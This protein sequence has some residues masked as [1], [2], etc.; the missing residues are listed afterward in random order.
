MSLFVR[1]KVFFNNKSFLE[2]V[3]L[4][5]FP[6]T[7]C[8]KSSNE[9][10]PNPADVKHDVIG[11]PN[12][13]SN[14]RPVLFYIPPNET[15]LEQDF[16]IEREKVQKWNED[17]WIKHNSAFLKE[18]NDF[19]QKKLETLPRDEK[20]GLSAEEMSE[21][22]KAFLDKNWKTHFSYNFQW[23]G[24]NFNLLYLA[25]KVQISKLRGSS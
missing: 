5:T 3:P 20:T 19:R 4:S 25:L 23:Y 18:S 11:P 16:R 14:L 22:Y 15:Q 8:V 7:T 13:T 24:K 2:F 6:N 10:P 12:K 17:F 21:F 1:R 9:P